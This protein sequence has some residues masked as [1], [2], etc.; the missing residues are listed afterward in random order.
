MDPMKRWTVYA[1]ILATLLLGLAS[2]APKSAAPSGTLT[3]NSTTRLATDQIAKGSTVSL[4][5][6]F[7]GLRKQDT[8]RVQILCL[9]D[10][11]VVYGDA[12][13]LSGTPQR[14]TFTLGENSPTAT[15]VWE[16]GDATCRSDLFYIANA[17]GGTVHYL[18]NVTFQATG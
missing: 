1:T 3:M 12:I 11:G 15:S 16:T 14:V 10:I 18:A 5:A 7:A 13:T 6:T 4:D 9:Q 2:A 17:G 8:V